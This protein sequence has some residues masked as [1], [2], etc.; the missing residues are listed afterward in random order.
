MNG[1]FFRKLKRQE[2]VGARSTAQRKLYPH[3]RQS[4]A[5]SCNW[6]LG[7]TR[8]LFLNIQ[9]GQNWNDLIL[10]ARP[11]RVPFL[12]EVEAAKLLQG[13]GYEISDRK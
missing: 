13:K 4:G 9:N 8:R 5:L 1:K 6:E 2:N 10:A 7:L 11:N 3:A 12:F